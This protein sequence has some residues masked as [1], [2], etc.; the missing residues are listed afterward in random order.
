MNARKTTADIGLLDTESLSLAENYAC[1]PDA[2]RLARENTLLGGDETLSNGA[3]ATLTFL[4]KALDAK[5][6]VEIGTG[7]GVTG[8]ALFAGMNPAGILT[9]IDS[10]ADWQLEARE[11]FLAA[12]ITARRFRTIAGVVLDVLPKLSDGV[13]DLVFV[14][15]DKLEYVEYVAQAVRLLRPGGVLLINDA[16]WHNLVA[17]PRNED[18]ETVIMREALQAV[19]ELGDF[20]PLLIPLGSG[21][22]AAVRG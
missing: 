3:C 19:Q 11:A 4:A 7:T 15:G 9:T 14:N 10:E 17:D 8:L 20:T 18:D 12:D 22:L 13:Y 1:L 5:A 21:L 16:L 6:V 2:L